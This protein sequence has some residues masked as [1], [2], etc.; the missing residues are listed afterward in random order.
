MGKSC[1]HVVNSR[2]GKCSKSESYGVC[3]PTGVEGACLLLLL[4]CSTYFVVVVHGASMELFSC[5][6][7]S[8]LTTVAGMCMW[9]LF[10][11]TLHGLT[12][13]YI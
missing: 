12:Q 13:E 2:K 3:G 1:V 7:I 5:P 9:T 4:F 8:F 11:E 6:V 10:A